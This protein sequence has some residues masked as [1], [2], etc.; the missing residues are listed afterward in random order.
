MLSLHRLLFEPLFLATC[1]YA[2][3]RGGVPERIAALTFALAATLSVVLIPSHHGNFEHI[4]LSMVGIDIGVLVTMVALLV[5]AQ[6]LW[7]IWMAAFQAVQLVLHVPMLLPADIDSWAY[8][9]AIAS[10]SYP[11][12]I[13]LAVAT[14][15]H[16]RRLARNGV[17]PS[18]RSF[19]AR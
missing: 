4:E 15:L 7:P 2:L 1:G 5:F 19:S 11:M 8:W 18:W 14:R 9:R 17:D 6:R 3:I 12:L 16:R 10:L 13:I